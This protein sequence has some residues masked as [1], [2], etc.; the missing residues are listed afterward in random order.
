MAKRLASFLF[1]FGL[2]LGLLGFCT[3]AFSLWSE[4]GPLLAGSFSHTAVVA[5]ICIFIALTLLR[6]RVRELK[7]NLDGFGA[8]P[9]ML[10]VSD[11][12]TRGY[13]FFQGPLIRGEILLFSAIALVW[14]IP[15][16]QRLSAMVALGAILIGAS[17]FLIAS[18]G[19]TLFSDDHATFIYRLSLLK[20]NFPDIPHY[21]PLWNAGLDARDFFATG[22]LNI[23]L[24]ASPL[25]Y[26]YRVWDVYNAIVALVLFGLLPISVYYAARVECLSRRAASVAV[27]LSLTSGLIWY[28]WGLKYGT[29]GF[30]T[31][32]AILPAV[33]ALAFKIV[34]PSRNIK[35]AEAVIF[36][37]ASSL[38]LFWT[39]SALVLVPVFCYGIM[40]CRSVFAQ[41]Y[42][43]WIVAGLLALN[44]PWMALFWSASNVGNFLKAEKPSHE[45]STEET[46]PQTE[47]V[48]FRHRRSGF[49]LSKSLK[50]IRETAVS[51]N[52][53]LW[54]WLIPGIFL[55]STHSRRL[56]CVEAVWLIFLGSVLVPIKPQLEFDRMLL[57]L[58]LVGTIPCAAALDRY[59]EGT[60]KWATRLLPALSGGFLLCGPFVGGS[61]ILNRS[62]EQYYFADTIVPDLAA[63]IEQNAENGR[64][65]FAGFVLHE[66]SG[67]HIAPLTIL[68]KTPLIASSPFHNLW[69]YT[70]AIPESFRERG[71][72][73]ID[74]FLDLMNV[75][76]VVAH[77][78]TWRDYFLGRPED[79]EVIWKEKGVLLFQRKKFVSSWFLSGQ[80]EVLEQDSS[81]VTIRLHSAEALLKF[82]FFPFLKAPGC[83]ISGKEVAPEVTLVQLTNCVPGEVVRLESIGPVRRLI[84]E[85]K[86]PW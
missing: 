43:I 19:R 24:L 76:L 44:I 53:L 20:D 31:T 60:E 11:W 61:V 82:R 49:D 59:F 10:F 38:M 12:L 69:R 29:L 63:S 34:D 22:A 45:V 30:I 4:H 23:F 85:A 83:N 42:I 78:R 62:V 81:G 3:G 57:M 68:S 54:V 41:K 8:L 50:V 17:S 14:F 51:T 70:D 71:K 26:F 2:A 52:P 73:G 21:Y 9:L 28:R 6:F 77:E 25:V 58:C 65:L 86:L 55:L 47:Q 32:A 15:L 16:R 67:G 33:L 37:A 48:A 72:E 40:Y 27:I 39:P 64:A 18:H 5:L 7:L 46:G 80:G 74:E 84:G 36:V 75:S 35:R 13:N 56:F 1:S 66:F 79:F